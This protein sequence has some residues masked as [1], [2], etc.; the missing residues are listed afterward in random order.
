MS[1]ERS[2]NARVG[3]A[4]WQVPSPHRR[5][6][7]E[8]GSHLERYA[9]RLSVVEINS[10]FYRP[11]AVHVYERWAA[12]VPEPFRFAVKCPKAITHECAL[13]RARQPLKRFLGEIA[14]LGRKLGPVLV[15]LLPSHAFEYRTVGRR[16]GM[17]RRCKGP[18]S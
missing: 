8:Q 12:T 16:R 4:G 18:I 7:P 9:S 14:G 13:R 5:F 1:D 3:T 10:S 11:H 6:F 2:P 15:Q 17:S